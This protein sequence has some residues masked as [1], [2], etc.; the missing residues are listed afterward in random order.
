MVFAILAG[1]AVLVSGVFVGFSAFQVILGSVGVVVGTW[2]LLTHR[3][4]PE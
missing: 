1:I 3:H 2:A 4:R